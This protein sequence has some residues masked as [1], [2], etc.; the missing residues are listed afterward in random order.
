VAECRKYVVSQNWLS[1]FQGESGVGLVAELVAFSMV[2]ADKQLADDILQEAEAYVPTKLVTFSDYGARLFV[3]MGHSQRNPTKSFEM[4]ESMTSINEVIEAAMK[5][6]QFVDITTMFITE[7][8]ANL[9]MLP[10]Q[11]LGTEIALGGRAS[12]FSNIFRDLA[13]AD[14]DRTKALAN[15]FQRK[16]LQIAMKMLIAISAL[17]KPS[18]D[19]NG[20]GA[21]IDFSLYGAIPSLYR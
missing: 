20:R 9:G 1:P 4:L 3:A 7:G 21:G 16:E 6:G 18:A 8:E 15:K 2:S 5:L 14:F 13:K 10:F 12:G 19:G 17:N 11:S